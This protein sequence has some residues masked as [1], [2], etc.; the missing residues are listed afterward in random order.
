MTARV[1]AEKE[2]RSVLST[3]RAVKASDIAGASLILLALVL[4]RYAQSESGATLSALGFSVW[5]YALA[6]SFAGVLVIKRIV[7]W[8]SVLGL[9]LLPYALVL[10]YLAVTANPQF[11][12]PLSFGTSFLFIK[13]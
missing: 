7:L 8:R 4:T 12:I 11:S 6:I 5:G 10:I 2:T 3:L 9:A 1:K 13:D